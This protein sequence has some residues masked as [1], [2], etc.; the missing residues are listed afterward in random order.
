MNFETSPTKFIFTKTLISV[1]PTGPTTTTTN[2]IEK[3]I[4]SK[5]SQE[6]SIEDG[7]AGDWG[8]FSYARFDKHVQKLKETT[9]VLEK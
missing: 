3:T 2:S 1:S 4:R 8:G 7:F 5:R 6:I 9:H